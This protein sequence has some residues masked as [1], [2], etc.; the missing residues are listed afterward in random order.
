M[1]NFKERDYHGEEHPD[2]DHLEVGGRH[3]SLGE[4]QV[5]ARKEVQMS[6]IYETY[7]VARMTRMVRLT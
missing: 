2:V 4:S 1:D 7:M 6:I 5:T 3:K